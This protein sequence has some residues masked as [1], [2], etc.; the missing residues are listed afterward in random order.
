MWNYLALLQETPPPP[1]HSEP[2]NGLGWIFM[3]CS[4]AFVILLTAWCYRRVLSL[5]TEVPE[6]AKDFHSA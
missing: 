2:L 4:L 6:P 1:A 5:P 3:I